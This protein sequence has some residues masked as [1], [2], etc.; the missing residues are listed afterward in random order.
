VIATVSDLRVF[1]GVIGRAPHT[2]PHARQLFSGCGSAE[3]DSARSSSEAASRC[4][5]IVTR[6]HR[7][8]Q[9]AS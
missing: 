1:F 3:L 6:V 9:S 8:S 2:V 7:R 5:Q 4:D